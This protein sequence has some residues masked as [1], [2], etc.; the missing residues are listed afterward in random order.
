MCLYATAGRELH[1]ALK[2]DLIYHKFRACQGQKKRYNKV[3][4]LR[5]ANQIHKTLLKKRLSL[6]VAES[7]SGGILSSLLTS[8]PG[9]S[10][11]F[12]LGIVAYSNKAK[13]SLL[14]IHPRLIKQKGAVSKEVAL[15][16]AKNVRKI[17]AAG[18]GLGITGIAGPEGGTPA[19]PVGTV[20]I[21][22]AGAKGALCKRLKLR[23]RR[24]SIRN[25]S[26]LKSLQL[27]KRIL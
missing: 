11:Y 19:K 15:L 26:A 18:F 9:S 22:A 2:I 3:S 27:L 6:A 1:P 4:M 13:I 25:Q 20:F 7:C 8:L 14:K 21:A 10:K 16:M 12:T 24:S 5:P 17:A 23:G